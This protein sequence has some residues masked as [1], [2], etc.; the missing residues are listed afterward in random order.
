VSAT[1]STLLF[2]T[3]TSQPVTARMLFADTF[4][5]GNYTIQFARRGSQ[6]TGFDVTNQRMRHVA[7][8]RIPGANKR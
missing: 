3:A 5:G 8:V 7:F 4:V 1:D 6:I 2:R